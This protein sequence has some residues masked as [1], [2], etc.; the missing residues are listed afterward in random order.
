MNSTMSGCSA[1]RITI[2]AARRGAARLAARLDDAGTLLLVGIVQ[3]A[4]VLLLPLF[5]SF[6]PLDRPSLVERLV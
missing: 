3:L 5:Y 1:L 2:L 6:K 4:P